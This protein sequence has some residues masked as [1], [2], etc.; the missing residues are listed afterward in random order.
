MWLGTKLLLR[1]ATHG[2]DTTSNEE[3][4]PHKEP[5]WWGS[6]LGRQVLTTFGFEKQW[7]LTSECLKITGV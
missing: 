6:A 2:R 4:I 7:G 3:R 5:Q 1:L